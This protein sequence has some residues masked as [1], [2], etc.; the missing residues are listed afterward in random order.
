MGDHQDS[1]IHTQPFKVYLMTFIALLFLT[2][3]TVAVSFVDIGGLGNDLLAVGI[4]G[5]KATAVT[6]YFMH[7]RF[8][9]KD[10]WAFIIYPASILLILIAALFLDYMSRGDDYVRV[11][12]PQSAMSAHGDAHG[13]GDHGDKAHGAATA[14]ENDHGDANHGETPADNAQDHGDDSATHDG[15][16]SD[17][18]ASSDAVQPSDDAQPTEETAT[19]PEEN[20]ENGGEQ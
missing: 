4:A 6:L 9:G 16:S 20:Q 18:E 11:T 1:H 2:V 10:V 7:G 8:E 12:T 3:I 17:D 19:P 15:S 5:I 13:S 14:G